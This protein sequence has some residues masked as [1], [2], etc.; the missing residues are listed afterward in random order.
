VATLSHKLT[1]THTIDSFKRPFANRTSLSDKAKNKA[2]FM[3]N[4]I[5]RIMES[6]WKLLRFEWIVSRPTIKS[7]AAWRNS[8]RRPFL[9][10]QRCEALTRSTVNTYV[11]IYLYTCINMFTYKLQLMKS[12]SSTLLLFFAYYINTYECM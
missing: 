1:H 2:R 9:L 4:K 3:L 7:P 12:E 10:A 6:K 11:H 5:K 8:N